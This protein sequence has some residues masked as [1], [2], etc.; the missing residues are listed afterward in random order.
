MGSAWLARGG[1]FGMGGSVRAGGREERRINKE[2]IQVTATEGFLA[3]TAEIGTTVRI[4]P[5]SKAES[6]QILVNDDDLV[7]LNANN[8]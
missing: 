1:W 5:D 7:S 6:L 8:Y 2:Y 3:E 4:S